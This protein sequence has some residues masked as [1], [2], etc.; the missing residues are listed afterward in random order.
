MV[1]IVCTLIAVSVLGLLFS[2]TRWMGIAA[3][4]LLTFRYPVPSLMAVAA[5]VAIFILIRFFK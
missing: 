2:T 5:G 4:A 1:P 3:I